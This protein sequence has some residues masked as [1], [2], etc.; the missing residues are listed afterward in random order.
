[1]GENHGGMAVNNRPFN[2]EDDCWIGKNLQSEKVEF[3]VSTNHLHYNRT[4]IDYVM[5]K[6]FVKIGIAR[7]P[8]SHFISSYN[9]Y[10]NLMPKLSYRLNPRADYNVMRKKLARTKGAK[11]PVFAAKPT[12][13]D[14]K[15]EMDVFLRHPWERGKIFSFDIQ[16]LTKFFVCGKY[17]C[18]GKIRYFDKIR[19]TSYQPVFIK[20]SRH[21]FADISTIVNVM[22]P[23]LRL[24]E[25]ETMFSYCR[26]FEFL[27]NY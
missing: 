7:E 17:Y 15:Y 9:F 20:T 11:K 21:V 22:K 14:I 12:K 16:N 24:H 26:A 3:E 18:F 6:P 1:M 19:L 10:H 4:A 27:F 8:E 2:L 25:L 13:D 23:F 5:K